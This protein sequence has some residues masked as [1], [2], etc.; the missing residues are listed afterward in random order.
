[1][2]SNSVYL[3]GRARRN[4]AVPLPGL[5]TSRWRRVFPGLYVPKAAL[6][7]NGDAKYY[8]VRA[9]SG[10]LVSRGFCPNCGSPLFVRPALLPDLVG[11]WAASLDDPSW[12][13]PKIELW[14]AS[15]HPWDALQPTLICCEKN[16]EPDQLRKWLSQ[17]D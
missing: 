4:L 12:Y 10:N 2:R 11:L 6:T 14:T 16:P 17:R 13:A 1:M 7:V 3:C 15:A 5:P 8:D 9:E